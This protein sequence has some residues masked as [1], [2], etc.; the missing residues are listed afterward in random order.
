[1]IQLLRAS[2][3]LGHFD[4]FIGLVLIATPLEAPKTWITR[5]CFDYLLE[6]ILNERMKEEK[7][8]V[9]NKIFFN[10][11]FSENYFHDWRIKER[12]TPRRWSTSNWLTTRQGKFIIIPNFIFYYFAKGKTYGSWKNKFIAWPWFLPGIWC[13]SSTSM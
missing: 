10:I 7:Y 4:T 6:N 12:I 9:Y 13:F 1:M 2:C 3:S 5:E 8:H 11:E